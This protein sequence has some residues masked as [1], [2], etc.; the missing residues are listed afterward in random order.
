[1]SDDEINQEI[2]EHLGWSWCEKCNRWHSPSNDQY[3]E[4]PNFVEDLNAMHSA[5]ETIQGEAA[6]DYY[7]RY[8][9]FV[10]GAE[11]REQGPMDWKKFAHATGRQRAEAF[12]KTMNLWK[13]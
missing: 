7:N 12:L 1:M 10:S 13:D 3:S 8:L 5:E 2:G 6:D 9:P 11:K 4:P